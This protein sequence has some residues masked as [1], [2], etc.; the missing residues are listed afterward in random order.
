[1]SRAA[2][3]QIEALDRTTQARIISRLETL[4]EEPRPPT[5]KKLKGEH[6]TWRVRVGDY[7]IVYTIEDNR[8]L[9]LVVKVGHRRE[10]YR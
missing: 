8:L 4:E 2:A 1:V 10:V 9:I 6:G 5:A 3:R 7:R